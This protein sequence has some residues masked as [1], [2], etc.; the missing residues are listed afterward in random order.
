MNQNEIYEQ[1]NNLFLKSSPLLR[2]AFALFV[3]IGILSFIGGLVSGQ[4]TRTWGSFL[5]NL[6]Y[7]FSFALGG[8]A[9]ANMQDI[10]GATWGRPIKR[11][12]ESFSAFLPYAATCFIIFFF[13][14]KVKILNADKLY[15]W[16]VDPNL[17]HDFPGKRDWLTLNFMIIRD[18]LALFIIL[19]LSRW[20]MKMTIARDMALVNG[21]KDQAFDLGLKCKNKLQ[22]WSAPILVIYS[23]CFSLLCFD[24]TM[25]LAP[26]W[27]STLWGGWSFSIMMQSLAFVL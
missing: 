14:I 13:C 1:R 6:M 12:H 5:L 16:I 11:L 23:I 21:D 27:F 26:T 10:I 2:G 22:Y 18:I 20:H 8:I 9:F 7:F 19:A 25:S 3:L 24:L 4:Y 15:S 17:L